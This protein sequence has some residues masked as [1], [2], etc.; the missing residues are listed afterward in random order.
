MSIVDAEVY[1]QKGRFQLSDGLKRDAKGAVKTAV[2]LLSVVAAMT[3]NVPY[4]GSISTALTELLKAQ[5]EVSKYRSDWRVVMAIAGQLKSVVDKVREACET[6]P[7]KENVLPPVLIEPF[8]DLE[9]CIAKALETLHL[10]KSQS[11]IDGPVSL[12][13]KLKLRAR[14]Y[15]NRGDLADLVKQC[16]SDMQAALD[17]FNTRLQ[18]DQSLKMHAMNSILVELRDNG[19]RAKSS[20]LESPLVISLPAAPAIFCG[21]AREVAQVVDLVINKSPA[22]VA[23]L[24]SGGVGKTSIAL[25]VLHH[26]A[27]ED[28]YS[29]RRYFVSCEA[30]TKTSELIQSLL[31]TFGLRHDPESRATPQDLLLSHLRTLSACILCLDNFETPWDSDTL[32]AELLLSSIAGLPHIALLITS[33]GSSRPGQ[34]KWTQPFMLPIE[35]FALDAAMDTWDIISGS[36]D[37]H[38][39]KLI[40]AVDCIPLAVTLLARLAESESSELL[41]ERW[42]LELTELLRVHGP[43]HRLTSLEISIKLSLNSPRIQGDD[44]SIQFFSVLCALPQGLL[45]SRISVFTDAF[46]PLLPNLRRSI[47]VLKQCSLASSSQNGF[48][49]VLSPIRHYMALHRPI[50]DALK[51]HLAGIYFDLVQFEPAD[52]AEEMAYSTGHIQPEIENITVVL[53]LC[54]NHVSLFGLERVLRS[55]LSFSQLCQTMCFYDTALLSEAIIRAGENFPLI[56]AEMWQAKGECS[57]YQDC[58]DEA[59]SAFSEA[60][61]LHHLAANQEGMADCMRR[62]GDVYVLLNQLDKAG[63][64]LRCAL[65][66]YSTLANR[67]GQASSLLSLGKLY[68]QLRDEREAENA[69]Q[70]AL[71]IFQELGD[72]VGQANCLRNLGDLHV[73]RDEAL[74]SMQSP[75]SMK[76]WYSSM[77]VKD[78]SQ[79]M[80]QVLACKDDFSHLEKA[81]FML[82]AALRVYRDTGDRRGEVNALNTLGHIYRT[83]RQLGKALIALQLALD[84]SIKILYLLGQG[85]AYRTIGMVHRD[86]VELPEAEACYKKALQLFE[87]AHDSHSMEMTEKNL[88]SLYM[89]MQVVAKVAEEEGTAGAV[90]RAVLPIDVP[91]SSRAE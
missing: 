10:C 78:G 69:L 29:D 7:N 44:G 60:H 21:R 51:A 27:V 4:L 42:N 79:H 58:H 82:Q 50:T 40:E 38:S 76:R 17:L 28:H 74:H 53:R 46:A 85:N 41:W 19:S 11:S 59:L 37:E 22:R 73:R 72:V 91:F 49:H 57:Y 36:H 34:T 77:L 12:A 35:P 2:A 75:S 56:V 43:D 47:T 20:S 81:E 16:R 71:L 61:R 6:N 88:K 55:I 70:N 24:G 54:L 45:E 32:S 25:A 84:L 63:S 18:I 80:V 13:R 33:R 9:K 66:T 48:L 39:I 5:D 8:N 68:Q 31:I 65:D 14:E 86:C 26:L 30:A 3:Q 89:D 23:I 15:V 52:Y 87:Q 67:P 62:M 1:T 90:T 64:S 83:E